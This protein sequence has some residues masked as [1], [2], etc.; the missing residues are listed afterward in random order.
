MLDLRYVRKHCMHAKS[1]Q[2]CPTL[3][4]PKTIACQTSLSTGFSKQKYWSGLPCPPPG[5]SSKGI[6]Q[7]Q[8]LNPHLLCLLHW[9]AFFFLTTSTTWEA[10]ESI[11]L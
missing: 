4:D 1:L 11:K 9:Q 10:Q 3:Y 2:S 6:F 8:G 5:E 7:T